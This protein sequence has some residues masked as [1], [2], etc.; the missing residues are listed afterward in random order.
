MKSQT[1]H[2]TKEK[3]IIQL[4]KYE[5]VNVQHFLNE[6][7][8]IEEKHD[9]DSNNMGIFISIGLHVYY[10]T[11]DGHPAPSHIVTW[12]LNVLF[13]SPSLVPRAPVRRKHTLRCSRLATVSLQHSAETH[14]AVTIL[15][16]TPRNGRQ[17]D[18]LG[19]P[20]GEV[21]QSLP[22]T[23]WRVITAKT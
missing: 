2:L 5:L 3:R 10:L 17:L 21:S 12:A 7:I 8:S 4:K 19:L 18:A 6:T 13:K 15:G 23:D 16:G 22:R 9:N 20:V 1:P 11:R 14:Q